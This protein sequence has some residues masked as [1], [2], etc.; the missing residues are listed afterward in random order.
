MNQ[1]AHTYDQHRCETITKEEEEEEAQIHNE[2][3]LCIE[4]LAGAA[5]DG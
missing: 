3:D 1:K 2:E 5:V 4:R